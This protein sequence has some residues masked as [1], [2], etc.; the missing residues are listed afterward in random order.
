MNKKRSVN[1]SLILGAVLLC[2]FLLFTVCALTVDVRPIGP[3]GSTVGFAMINGAFHKAVGAHSTAYTA[4]ELLGLL[5]WSLPLVFCILG[6]VQWIRRKRLFA[7]DADIFVLAGAYV[8][9]MLAYVLFE[10]FVVNHRP[11]LVDGELEA[12]YP[13]SH[14]LLAIVL[15]G[16][17]IR[18]L[19]TRLSTRPLKYIA[20]ACISSLL[21]GTVV[22]RLLSGVHWFTDIVAGVLLGSAIVFLC[23]GISTF[24]TK[25]ETT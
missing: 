17:A 3:N 14:T 11:I 12:S 4:S 21:I 2:L 23:N 13:S 15:F 6:I 19:L 9:M 25:K 5:A 1:L 24:V 20:V 22:C 7:V 10:I 18:Q 8:V 16:T